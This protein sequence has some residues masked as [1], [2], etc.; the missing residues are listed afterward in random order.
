MVGQEVTGVFANRHMKM[1]RKPRKLAKLQRKPDAKVAL[2]LRLPEQ[3]RRRLAGAAKRDGHSLNAEI[4]YR[5]E[6][7]DLRVAMKKTIDRAV[8]NGLERATE[9]AMLSGWIAGQ[10]S[11][12]RGDS[13]GQQATSRSAA[14]TQEACKNAKE[15]ERL[16]SFDAGN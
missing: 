3:L 8:R 12:F 5:L 9:R 15:A 11:P 1:A 10:Y 2:Q 16:A 4:L 13:N 7:F 6:A 14:Q